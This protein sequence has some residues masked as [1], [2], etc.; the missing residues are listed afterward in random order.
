MNRIKSIDHINMT[1]KN[2]DASQ[3]WYH[4]LFGFELVEEAVTD[5]VRWGIIRS[6]D[7]MLCLYEH[8][9]YVHLDRFELAERKFHG[10]AHFALRISDPQQWLKTATRMDVTILY[11]GKIRWPHSDSWYIQDPTGYEIEVVHW[12]DDDIQFEP[13][14]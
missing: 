9:D 14:T 3:R 8:P 10:M 6:A 4:E 12:D 7:S 2:F 1:V 5:G 13:L 11:D